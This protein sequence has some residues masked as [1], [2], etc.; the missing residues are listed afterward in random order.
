MRLLGFFVLLISHCTGTKARREIVSRM[1]SMSFDAEAVAVPKASHDPVKKDLSLV[2]YNVEWQIA[3]PDFLEKIPQAAK[4]VKSYL[5]EDEDPDFALIP[6]ATPALMEMLCPRKARDQ[7]YVGTPADRA[8]IFSDVMFE[9]DGSVLGSSS[10]RPCSYI[11][12]QSGLE[13]IAILFNPQ[14]YRVRRRSC[15]TGEALGEDR[16][17]IHSGD[18]KVQN[19]FLLP[20]GTDFTHLELTPPDHRT[21]LLAH[22]EKVVSSGIGKSLVIAAL[23]PGHETHDEDLLR[24]GRALDA[25]HEDLTSS[26]NLLVVAGDFNS[27]FGIHTPWKT[28]FE[29]QAEKMETNKKDKEKKKKDKEK[30]DKEIKKKKTKA[31]SVNTP[32]DYMRTHTWQFREAYKTNNSSF[33]NNSITHVLT[34][35]LSKHGY[36]NLTDA[37]AEGNAAVE[38]AAKPDELTCCCIFQ[39]KTTDKVYDY[40]HPDK[41]KH[42]FDHILIADAK[43][44]VKKYAV[45]VGQPKFPSSDHY[46]LKM[47]LEWN[48]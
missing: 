34:P 23:H 19:C 17:R 5:M 35:V 1:M 18:A 7:N 25:F 15:I 8:V 44:S 24:L 16:N 30:K 26:P 41:L 48:E 33:E 13:G 39:D 29:E 10:A 14:R 32:E 46:P 47:M 21:M 20:N 43:G 22:F 11:F 2:V 42:A 40:C 31:V 6:E 12:D 4:N 36:A 37:A 45:T 38:G 9:S 28:S 3:M 27:H